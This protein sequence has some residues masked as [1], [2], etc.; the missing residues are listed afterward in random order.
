MN[1][2]A[3]MPLPRRSYAILLVALLSVGVFYAIRSWKGTPTVGHDS[4]AATSR[5]TTS[6][7][8]VDGPLQIYFSHTYRNDPELPK[9]DEDNIDRHLETF[10]DDARVALDAAIFQLGSQRIAMALIRAHKRG[11]QVRVVSDADFM[12]DREME[13]LVDA[14]IPIR[15]DQRSALMHNKFF[16]ADGMRVWTGSYNATD[17]CSFRNNNNAVQI[18]SRDLAENYELEFDEMFLDGKFGPRSPSLLPHNPVKVGSAD[19]YSYFAPEDDVPAKIVRIVRTA[20]RSIHLMAFSFSDQE[21]GLAM[22][23]AAGDGVDVEGVIET[24]G[25]RGPR[26]QAARFDSSGIQLLR[27]GNNRLMHHKVIIVDGLWTITGSYNFTASAASSNDENLLIIKSP[28]V[29]RVFEAE[30]RR[31]RAMAS[32]TP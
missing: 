1:Y 28:D 10:I 7:H 32:A 22:I 23:K 20:R 27:D 6:E 21:I 16:V 15:F 24:V 31:I 14:G 29:A 19:V 8:R 30:Y 12:H 3:N 9:N 26:S 25:S 17:N 13:Q 5:E 18:A 4:P 11:V 2:R